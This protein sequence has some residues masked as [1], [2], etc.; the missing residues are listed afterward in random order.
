MMTDANRDSL[1][2]I[3]RVLLRCWLLGF[4][5]LLVWFAATQVV[6]MNKFV[7]EL[8]TSMFGLSTHEVDLI[9][10]CGMGLLKLCVLT[11]FFIPWL[12]IRLVLRSVP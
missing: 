7:H 9:F 6:A 10:Y 12:A 1:E 2:T 8:H 3:A 4:G 11:L 5:L